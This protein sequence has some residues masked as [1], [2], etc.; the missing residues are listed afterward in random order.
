MLVVAEND[1]SFGWSDPIPSH[2]HWDYRSVV[3]RVVRWARNVAQ[4]KDDR[5][6]SGTGSKF[7]E[8]G[9]IGPV[10]GRPGV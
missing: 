5:M 1:P 8:G 2:I 6:K 7:V 3:R 4:G 10:P 9:T